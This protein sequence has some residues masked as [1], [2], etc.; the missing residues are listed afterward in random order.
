MIEIK[1]YKIRLSGGPIPNTTNE[2]TIPPSWIKEHKIEAGTVVSVI[3]GFVMVVLP[4]DTSEEEEDRILAFVR[5]GKTKP[6]E[7]GKKC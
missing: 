7:K 2:I 5:E 1:R 6:N 3:A 4:P